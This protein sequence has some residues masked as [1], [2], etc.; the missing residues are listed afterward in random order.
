MEPEAFEQV[1]GD[2]LYLGELYRGHPRAMRYALDS[3]LSAHD[4]DTTILYRT[5]EMYANRTYDVAELHEAMLVRFEGIARRDSLVRS[6]ED[7]LSRLALP[8]DP[9]DD[10]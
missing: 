7:S 2:I 10:E 1:Y 6:K 8:V 3:L 5:A 9:G 4:I